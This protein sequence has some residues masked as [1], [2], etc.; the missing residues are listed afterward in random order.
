MHSIKN[1]TNKEDI[2]NFLFDKTKIAMAFVDRDGSFIRANA[3]LVR[4]LEYT[5]YE[6]ERMKFSE[7][8]HPADLHADMDLFRKTLSGEIEGYPMT[9]RYITKTG[10]QIWAKLIVTGVKDK[11]DMVACF[12]SQIIPV[13]E[14]INKEFHRMSEDSKSVKSDKYSFLKK[15]WK[16]IVAF[17]LTLIGGYITWETNRRTAEF[18]NER[19]FE[20]IESHIDSIDYKLDMLLELKPINT[21]GD[22]PD[23]E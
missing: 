15:E 13:E 18:K 4:V 2:D 17:S 12:F 3:E 22:T 7:I 10:K 6:L 20:V 21:S 16:W 8:T 1:L 9:K 14:E 5:E 19:R 23:G 11:N